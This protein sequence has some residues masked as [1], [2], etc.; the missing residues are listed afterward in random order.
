MGDG[1]TYAA[2][3]E[4]GLRDTNG[5]EVGLAANKEDVLHSGMHY[6]D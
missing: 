3:K 1:W 6:I 5:A 2:G 4:V